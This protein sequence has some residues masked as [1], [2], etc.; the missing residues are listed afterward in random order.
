MGGPPSRDAIQGGRGWPCSG[1]G[2]GGDCNLWRPPPA[3]R[4]YLAGGSARTRG[5]REQVGVL[6]QA[7]AG[8]LDLHDHGVVEQPVQQRG[9][10]DG[11]A[12][13]WGMPQNLIDESL[14]SECLTRNTRSTASGLR[15][16]IANQ[17]D[18]R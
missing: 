17:P 13:H 14:K 7:V 1:G 15:S 5:L 2:C 11:V 8:A 12:E 16:V 9:G 4:H 10:D 6:S 3:T 18:P